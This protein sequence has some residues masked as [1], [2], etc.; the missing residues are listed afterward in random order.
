MTRLRFTALA[1]V[2]LSLA[3]TGCTRSGDSTPQVTEKEL[4]Y[5]EYQEAVQAED[6][7]A[8][9]A[10]LSSAAVDE[11]EHAGN[12]EVALSMMNSMSPSEVN[13]REPV[14]SKEGDDLLLQGSGLG[15]EN[16]KGRV[17][18][19]R[20]E[21]AWRIAK[22]EWE[23][24]PDVLNSDGTVLDGDQIPWDPDYEIRLGR[25]LFGAPTLNRIDPKYLEATGLRRVSPAPFLK[26][27][28]YAP[29]AARTLS[30]EGAEFD[31]L[32]FTPEGDYLVTASYGDYTVRVWDTR[33]WAQLSTM[34]MSDR[35]TGVAASPRGDLFVTGDV[36]SNLTFWSIDGGSADAPLSVP[37]NAGK[38]L[39]VAISGNGKLLATVSWDQQ[40]SLW[41]LD[42]R[43]PLQRV[44]TKLKW[45][46][47][48]FSPAGPVL[49]AGAATNKFAL[50]DL[51]TGKGEVLTVPK[52][53]PESDVSEIS[54]S[55][56]GEFILTGHGDSSI[57]VWTV[58]EKK[59]LRN[60][61]VQDAGTTTVAFSPD[62]K[63]F[64]TGHTNK[65]I[66][67]WETETGTRLAVLKRHDAAINR[68]AFSPDGARLAS[69]GED[70]SLIIWE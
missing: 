67:I 46:C 56:D 32:T 35:P 38:H 53:H 7:S 1:A 55:P 36:Y 37:A 24:S 50:W 33:S 44:E 51:R 49:A 21:N 64:A 29:S 17:R 45:R 16:S 40:L 22:V 63:V 47:V 2:V 23:L 48:A 20:E 4:V 3:V 6:Q 19:V 42:S 8:L 26:G 30:E 14:P 9:R 34:K 66:Y 60:F 27:Q 13:V 43:E 25:L 12:L 58:R 5:R 61:Y 57:S 18:F 39:A 69:T 52:V 54:F 31:H 70:N 15:F 68:L 62:G 28:G 41:S 11:M 59:L 10:V 65:H